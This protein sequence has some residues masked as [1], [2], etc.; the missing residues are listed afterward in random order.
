MKTK[1]FAL[2][3]ALLLALLVLNAPVSTAQ[4]DVEPG[5]EGLLD[6]QTNLDNLMGLARYAM[7]SFSPSTDW[8]RGIM[9]YIAAFPDN[10]GLAAG[11]YL[12]ALP[13]VLV[14]ISYM[15]S[16]PLLLIPILGQIASFAIQIVIAILA[17][18]IALIGGYSVY[19]HSGEGGMSRIAGIVQMVGGG[20]QMTY[21]G[22]I[23]SIFILYPISL[24]LQ[25]LGM[26]G[27]A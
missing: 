20:V 13:Y 25:L 15:I 18:S 3:A 26:L 10:A 6:F 1:L 11:F 23:L 16:L 12:S 2:G 27:V 19:S 4:Q 7:D 21:F 9:D 24:I 14:L 8:I 22:T 17:G 5:I